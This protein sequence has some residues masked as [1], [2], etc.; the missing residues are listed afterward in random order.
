[1]RKGGYKEEGHGG[2]QGRGE[3]GTSTL[4]HTR[5]A[6]YFSSKQVTETPLTL[7]IN[8]NTHH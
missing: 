1:M 8:L 4:T 7:R 3:G 6:S 2:I 5:S